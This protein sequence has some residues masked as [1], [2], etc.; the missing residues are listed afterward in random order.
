MQGIKLE[1][2][3]M[4]EVKP[5]DILPGSYWKDPTDGIWY[6]VTPNALW[7]WLRRHK[8]IEHED[9]TITVPLSDSGKANSILVGNGTGRGA[10]ETSWHGWI[11]HGVWKEC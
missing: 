7:G 6:I 5:S 9:G 1:N 2:I 10:D 4:D 11:D 3:V 8:V